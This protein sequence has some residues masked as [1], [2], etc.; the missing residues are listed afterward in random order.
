MVPGDALIPLAAPRLAPVRFDKRYSAP[1]AGE[2]SG[3]S[4]RSCSPARMH[5]IAVLSAVCVLMLVGLSPLANAENAIG[6]WPRGEPVEARHSP[7]LH[8]TGVDDI[9]LGAQSLGG[10]GYTDEFCLRSNAP[11]AYRV[12]AQPGPDDTGFQLNNARAGAVPFKVRYRAGAGAQPTQPLQPGAYSSAYAS[13]PQPDDACPQGR[14]VAFDLEVPANQRATQDA[15]I[16]S[17]A[18]TLMLVVE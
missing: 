12:V 11:L 1:A 4:A 3:D 15:E 8:A 17:G 7:A 16:Y 5:G 10:H 18:L 9:Q 2:R 6:L 14:A 13:T